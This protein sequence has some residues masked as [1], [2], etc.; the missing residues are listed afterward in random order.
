[1][2]N[3]VRTLNAISRAMSMLRVKITDSD[4]NTILK[5]ITNPT[6]NTDTVSNENLNKNAKIENDNDVEMRE[7][8]Y[9]MS[10]DEG[11]NILGQGTDSKLMILVK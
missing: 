2:R 11:V 7:S 3:P 6:K 10:E 4:Q 8:V 5:S 1:M 9:N